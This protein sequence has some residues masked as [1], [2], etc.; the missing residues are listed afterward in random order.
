M[1]VQLEDIHPETIARQRS[2]LLNSSYHQKSRSFEKERKSS[3]ISRSTEEKKP[4]KTVSAPSQS[5]PTTPDD[6]SV[7]RSFSDGQDSLILIRSVTPGI[8]DASLRIRKRSNSFSTLPGNFL[9]KSFEPADLGKEIDAIS[10]N[11]TMQPSK[12]AS[13]SAKNDAVS[14]KK[15]LFSS[16]RTSNKKSRSLNPSQ[17]DSHSIY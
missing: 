12:H 6:K 2:G 15:G 7:H 16:T 17:F 10:R 14:P 8:R 1:S 4:V 13:V 11:N 9:C 3:E 5:A